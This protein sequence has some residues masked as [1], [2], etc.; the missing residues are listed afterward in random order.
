[1]HYQWLISVFLKNT[2]RDQLLQKAY[3]LTMSSPISNTT[4]LSLFLEILFYSM[5][6]YW[7]ISS[8]R[9]IKRYNA[10]ETSPKF[11]GENFGQLRI[12]YMQDIHDTRHLHAA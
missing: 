8:C 7:F 6:R 5:V 9:K 2:S 10:C 4:T 1:M 11:S 12:V 3:N